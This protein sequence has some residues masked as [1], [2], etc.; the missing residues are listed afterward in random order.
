MKRD[1]RRREEHK[2]RDKGTNTKITAQKES[3]SQREAPS[4]S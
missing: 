2:L 4:Y 3:M 1:L